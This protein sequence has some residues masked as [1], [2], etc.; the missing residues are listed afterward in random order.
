MPYENPPSSDSGGKYDP[1]EFPDG[2]DPMDLPPEPRQTRNAPEYGS[3]SHQEIK[4]P[5]GIVIERSKTKVP[6]LL[7]PSHDPV[8]LMTKMFDMAIAANAIL[9]EEFD[10][11]EIYAAYIDMF[12]NDPDPK[13]RMAAS[14][15]LLKQFKD[16]LTAAGAVSR[17]TD[18]ARVRSPDGTLAEREVVTHH[19]LRSFEKDTPHGNSQESDFTEPLSLPPA[20]TVDSGNE[21]REVPEVRG[22]QGEGIAP[23]NPVDN[24]SGGSGGGDSGK[25]GDS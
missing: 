17:V 20:G 22:V 21:S 24:S 2:I 23:V 1:L 5:D 11:H 14:D 15:R 3:K 9:V 8:K 19:V 18:V 4:T 7:D 12:R 13:V 16:V 6:F 25:G 10:F